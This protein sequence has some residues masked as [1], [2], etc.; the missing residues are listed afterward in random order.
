MLRFS[1]FP[2]GDSA[3]G[4]RSSQCLCVCVE[5]IFVVFR[6]WG[7]ISGRMGVAKKVVPFY[8]Q[9]DVTNC[10]LNFAR[11]IVNSRDLRSMIA[12]VFFF[13]FQE[14]LL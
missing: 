9:V 1:L 7:V 8:N 3:F 13:F 5:N 11:E 12:T 4:A 6:E 2:A 10:S 14:Y